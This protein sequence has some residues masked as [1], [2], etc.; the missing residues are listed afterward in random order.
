MGNNA[1]PA[2]AAIYARF[3][4][5][6]QDERS[7][8]DQVALC[9]DYARR[10]NW[11]VAATY[12]DFAVSGATIHGRHSYQRMLDDAKARRFEVILA[13]DVDRFA[14]NS[15]DVMRLKEVASFL[16]VRIFTVA[17][18][19]ANELLFGFKGLMSA[20]WLQGHILKVRR[21]MAGRIRAGAS[22]GG[23]CYGYAAVQGQPGVLTIVEHE[24]EVIRRIFA[25]YVAGLTP[26]QI[27]EALN[28]EGIAAPRGKAWNA[29]TINGSKARHYGIIAN[30]LYGGMRMWNRTRF[31]K[32]PSTGKRV[33]RINEADTLMR[34][35][36]PGLAIVSPELFRAAQAR[37]AQ[38]S[39]GKP[40]SHRAP[41]R[42]L[43]GLLRCA[44]CGG[45]M[46][47]AGH[48][49]TG[50]TRV[51]CS[52]HVES[53]TCPAPATFYLDA[54]EAATFKGLRAEL[55]KP[56]LL[57]EYARTYH[58]ERQRLAAGSSRR[59]G[60]IERRLGELARELGRIV[61]AII[62]GLG[63]ED[64]LRAR[65]QEL[66]AERTALEREQAALPTA[67]PEVV[68]LHPAALR[69][70]AEQVD[71]LETSLGTII[72][73]PDAAS[74][75]RDLIESVTV[76]RSVKGGPTVSITG[77]MEHLLGTSATKIPR[78]GGLLVAGEDPRRYPRFR[79]SSP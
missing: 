55:R 34:A 40:S 35:P 77:R 51:R 63:D 23:R 12:E 60:Q 22:A 9:R 78:P 59:R 7:I 72:S 2:K 39:V 49:K 42:P 74:A 69:R 19:E 43:S 18:G 11:H 8:A 33:S 47:T 10:N 14:R 71:R 76:A 13:E 32:D 6:L 67:M 28:R 3:S 66:Q 1:A 57:A 65:T 70:Y 56:L 4:S 20:H 52:R 25:D 41:R 38:R 26:R 44:A 54:I 79:I 29:S 36:A 15:A 21:G 17:D 48:D 75:L 27:A 24:A 16:E 31:V 62:K 61:D 5:D 30:P 73:D 37:K 45:G 58:A 64:M 46:S 50:R 53:A 68:T